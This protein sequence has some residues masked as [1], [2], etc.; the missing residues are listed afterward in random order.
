MQGYIKTPIHTETQETYA[1]YLRAN[2]RWMRRA[3]KLREKR[4]KEL[5]NKINRVEFSSNFG[6]R[7]SAFR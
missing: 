5:T 2:M 1:D 3:R 7:H 4:W 6:A